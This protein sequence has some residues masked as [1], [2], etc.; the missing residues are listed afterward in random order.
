MSANL[1][2][3]VVQAINF[4]LRATTQENTNFT[5]AL[6]GVAVA[7]LLLSAWLGGHLVHVLGVTQPGHVPSRSP[8]HDQLHP[9]I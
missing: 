5:L 9:Q 8:Q 6:S 1:A 2:I 7:G 3:V 4:A